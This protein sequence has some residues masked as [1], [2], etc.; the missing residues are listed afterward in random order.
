M[1]EDVLYYLEIGEDQLNAAPCYF[2]PLLTR[3]PVRCNYIRE[4]SV[5]C[6]RAYPWS[7]EAFIE[8]RDQLYAIIGY[9]PDNGVVSEME[10]PGDPNESRQRGIWERVRRLLRS[11]TGPIKTPPLASSFADFPILPAVRETK[12]ARRS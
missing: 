6:R 9:N 11:S 3:C 1:K 12:Y 7:T 10:Y 5:T 2:Q 4:I 8:W